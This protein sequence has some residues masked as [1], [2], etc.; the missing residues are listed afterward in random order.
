[1]IGFTLNNIQASDLSP[2]HSDPTR[3]LLH[4]VLQEQPFHY[5]NGAT[6]LEAV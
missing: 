2:E 3:V 4:G 1:L 6:L 5:L